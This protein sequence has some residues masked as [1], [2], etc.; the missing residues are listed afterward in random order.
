[1]GFYLQNK[2]QGGFLLKGS[3][4]SRQEGN[5]KAKKENVESREKQGYTTQILRGESVLSCRSASPRCAA[6]AFSC[7]LLSSLPPQLAE[8]CLQSLLARAGC[9]QGSAAA[10]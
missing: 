4:I 8:M 5:R 2:Q 1:M 3:F 7:P 10:S 9:Q 6:L